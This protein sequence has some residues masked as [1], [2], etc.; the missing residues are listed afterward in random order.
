MKY[1]FLASFIIQSLR[2]FV[3]MRIWLLFVYSK[4]A[5]DEVK[6]FVVLFCGIFVLRLFEVFIFAISSISQRE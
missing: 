5:K 6:L 2:L 3:E 1:V 4:M